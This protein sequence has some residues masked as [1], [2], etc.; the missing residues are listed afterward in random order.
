MIDLLE[1]SADGL[2]ETV[3]R[4][5]ANGLRQHTGSKDAALDVSQMPQAEWNRRFL[6]QYFTK[7]DSLLHNWANSQCD[8]MRRGARGIKTNLVGPRGAAKSTILNLAYPLRCAVEQTEPLI[9][10]VAE[11]SEQA[12]VNLEAIRAELNDNELLKEAYPKSTGR[13]PI[14]KNSKIQLRNGVAVE[15]FGIGKKLRGR[16]NRAARPSLIILDDLQSDQAMTSTLIRD[17]NWAWLNGSLMKAGNSRTNFINIANAIHREAI[18]SRLELTPGWTNRVFRSIEQWPANMGL[19]EQW[20]QIY[21]DINNSEAEQRARDFFEQHQKT[22][23]AGTQVL[24]P[25]EEDIYALMCMREFGGRNAF[26]REK[27]CRPINSE[28]CEWPESYFDD[29]IWFDDWP[30][31]WE[32]RA[33]ALD[34]S[35]GKHDTRGDYSAFAMLQ[36]TGGVLYVD[37][38]LARRS[39]DLIVSDGVNLFQRFK[40]DILAVESVAFQELLIKN[41]QAEFTRC[42]MA[43]NPMPLDN[44]SPPKQMRIRRLG[45]WLAQRRIK[46]RRG[47]PGA[48]LTVAQLRDFPDPHTHDDGPDAVEM[49]LRVAG[50]LMTRNR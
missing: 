16:R 1:H 17:K 42:G 20:A 40:P 22:M 3:L 5:V 47:S 35:K 8:R 10:T 27:Q 12:E 24:W 2:L 13:G 44:A 18:G 50:M 23:L 31:S 19:W 45:G 49:A 15:A 41:F 25:E 26:E 37:C 7:A 34:P 43:V 14:W 46:F 11:T 38:D 48:A 28:Q 21:C 9:W 32:C 33:M 6:P 4:G 30:T 36:Y 29:H 39:T